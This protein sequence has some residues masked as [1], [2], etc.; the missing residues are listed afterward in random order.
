VIDT[1]AQKP[2]A[3]TNYFDRS[4]NCNTNQTIPTR[5]DI[6]LLKSNPFWS[7]QRWRIKRF[8]HKLAYHY[9]KS[10]NFGHYKDERRNVVTYV[11]QRKRAKRD[12]DENR[13]EAEQHRVC[14]RSRGHRAPPAWGDAEEGR[15]PAS[16]SGRGWALASDRGGGGWA[17]A[18]GEAEEG[19][20]QHDRWA[21][22]PPPPGRVGP[23]PLG[24][25]RTL[26]RSR[27]RAGFWERRS[28]VG[29][30]LRRGGG[31]RAQHG[32]RVGRCREGTDRRRREGLEP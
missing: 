30:G 28:R 1:P 12:R 22:P 17:P 20:A 15:A 16:E 19:R 8:L 32:R 24:R 10:I 18:C 26:G 5:N 21:G 7:L 14:W 6:L 29:A 27:L 25:A 23:P 4:N 31:G 3:A 13:G 9:S 11:S 2:L